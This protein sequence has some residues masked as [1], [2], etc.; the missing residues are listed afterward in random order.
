MIIIFIIIVVHG[1]YIS[2]SHKKTE[3]RRRM[4]SSTRVVHGGIEGHRVIAVLSSRVC[5]VEE[6]HHIRTFARAPTHSPT[7]TST[8]A[9][10][11]R[12]SK[13]T[14]VVDWRKTVGNRYHTVR[15]F[16]L[17]IFKYPPARY[18]LIRNPRTDC[19]TIFRREPN[20]ERFSHWNPWAKEE[21]YLH[22]VPGKR[23]THNDDDDITLF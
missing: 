20:A 7:H 22:R 2:D 17:F 9:H 12:D 5:R 14:K 6:A 16:G 1:V 15:T 10:V 21:R 3:Y 8:H 19:T 18:P 13:R 23:L 11:L 4:G